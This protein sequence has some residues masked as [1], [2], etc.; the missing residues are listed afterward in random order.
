MHKNVNRLVQRLSF[1]RQN[2]LFQRHMKT[3][4]PNYNNN[5]K[6]WTITRILRGKHNRLPF[7]QQ[8]NRLLTTDKER[9]EAL[10]NNFLTN[11]E[12]TVN[13]RATVITERDVRRSAARMK[14]NTDRNTDASTF[15]KSKEIA[16]IIR[17]LPNNKAPGNDNV[18]NLML[19]NSSR[20][21]LV[22]L[23]YIFN[24]CIM[25]SYFPDKWKEAITVPIRKPGKTSQEVSSYRPISLL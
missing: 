7:I 3:F 8:S 19:K 16:Q 9:A 24:A 15:V 21:V 20:K 5:R 6:L 2:Q 22:A 25:L 23:T 1:K 4:K 11:H 18:T 10:A 13:Q 12:T 14:S 17:F